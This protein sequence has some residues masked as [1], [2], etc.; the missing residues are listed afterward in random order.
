V[1]DEP[2]ENY[3]IYD[4]EYTVSYFDETDEAFPNPMKGFRPGIGPGSNSFQLHEYGRVYRQYVKYSDL[5]ASEGDTV[6]RIIDWS[7]RSWA[8]IERRNIKVIPRVVLTYP[9]N[10]QPGALSNNYWPDDIPQKSLMSRWTSKELEIRLTNF[11]RKLGEAWDNDPRVAAI[12]LGLWGYWG[13]HHLL[14]DGRIPQSMQKILGDV[15]SSAFQ[16]K[17]VMIRY[18]ETFSRYQF[19]FY[20][21]SFALSDDGEG[22]NGIV[23]RNVWQTQMISGE[24]AYDWGNRS[25]LGKTP[26]ETVENNRYTDFL[27]NWIKRT[28][29]SSLGWV[30]DYNQYA[31]NLMENAARIQKTLGYRFVIKS[32]IYKNTINYDEE[33]K[34]GF[35][36]LNVGSAPFYYRWPVEISL[37]DNYREPVFKKSIEADIRSWLPG[38]TYTLNCVIDDLP[39]E[40]YGKTYIVAVSINDPAGNKPSIRFANINYYNGGR[41]PLG[42]IGLGVVPEKSDLGIFNSIK[43]DNSL[44]YEL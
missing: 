1:N 9:T 8:G 28:H 36:V 42:I 33:L 31:Q 30:S 13:E 11:V 22:G 16:N 21:D 44:S 14:S 15:F 35:K 37:L 34:I 43:D 6:Q 38:G 12:E 24:V 40:L 7:N 23:R 20:W 3:L 39:L 5:E 32:A 18:P 2:W 25:E 29:A 10:N 26:N 27:I 19:G 41:T 17:K 4:N